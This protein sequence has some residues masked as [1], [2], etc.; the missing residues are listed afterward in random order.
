MS[1]KKS[2]IATEI[3]TFAEVK[4]SAAKRKEEVNKKSLEVSEKIKKLK[5][6]HDEPSTLNIDPQY[7]ELIVK[8]L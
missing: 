4:A 1:I 5:A 8:M 7:Q 2:K 6:R 3:K